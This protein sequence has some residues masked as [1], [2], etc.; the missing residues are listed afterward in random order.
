MSK[1]KGLIFA[2]AP[3]IL[4][5]GLGIIVSVRTGEWHWFARSGSLLIALAILIFSTAT[6]KSYGAQRAELALALIGTLIWAFG[7]LLGK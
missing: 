6:Y 7:D 4:I 3:A 2:I 5:V 1:L